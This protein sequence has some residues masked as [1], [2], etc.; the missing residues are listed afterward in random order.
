[1]ADTLYPRLEGANEARKGRPKGAFSD[2]HASLELTHAAPRGSYEGL[3]GDVRSVEEVDTT[4]R[5]NS[6]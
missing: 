1:M 5:L 2:P 6:S 4:L 3:A